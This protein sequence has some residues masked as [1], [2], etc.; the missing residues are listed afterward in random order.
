MA[1]PITTSDL[2]SFQ[3]Q[4]KVKFEM[5]FER[6]RHEDYINSTLS[7]YNNATGYAEVQ[8]EFRPVTLT[9]AAVRALATTDYLSYLD[10]LSGITY[11]RMMLSVLATRQAAEAT[12]GQPLIAGLS[13]I[14]IQFIVAGE[15][16]STPTSIIYNGSGRE[17]IDVNAP[18][19]GCLAR[20]ASKFG[21]FRWRSNSP[22]ANTATA[23]DVANPAR[24][25]PV[26]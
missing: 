16:A 18:Y 8:I 26:T 19:R 11:Q 22:T 17:S 6:H 2:Q 20:F 12:I 1:F 21:A 7:N 14:N 3:D 13:P 5:A 23:A 24:W 10:A 15:T 9:K 4:Y 25:E